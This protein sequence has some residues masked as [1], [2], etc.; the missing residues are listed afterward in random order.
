M[1]SKQKYR[2]LLFNKVQKIETVNFGLL[3]CILSDGTN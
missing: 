3:V 1:S 2:A